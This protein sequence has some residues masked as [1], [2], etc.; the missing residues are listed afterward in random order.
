MPKEKRLVRRARK[1]KPIR[2]VAAIPYRLT[3]DG[4][5]EV[6]LVTSNTTRRF[7]VPK[8]WPM[9]SKTG[10][11][12]AAQEAFEEAGVMG[13]A[14]EKPFGAY[15]YWKRLSG[16]FVKVNVKV[17]LMPVDEVLADWEEQGKRARAWLSP[18]DA[19]T[20]IDEPELAALVLSLA[21]NPPAPPAKA[22]PRKAKPAAKPKPKREKT[23]EPKS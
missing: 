6:L 4:A 8:G 17:F 23:V 9:K 11:E 1:N 12:A 21:D 22:K 14:S 7:I 16:S 5:V 15:A 2:Q 20:L 19:S 10:R 18:A 13:E 3:V